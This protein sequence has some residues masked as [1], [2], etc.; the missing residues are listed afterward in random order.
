MGELLGE[1]QQILQKLEN[2][3]CPAYLVGGGVRDALMGR[4]I[5]DYDIATAA[6]PDQVKG[7][8]PEFRIID[9]GLKHGTVT[10][11][12]EIGG[13]EITTFRTESTYSDH[14]RPD[15]VQFTSN[16]IDDLSRRDF[17]M[18]AIALG[19]DGLHDPFNGQ[20]DIEKG[21]IR[22]VGDPTTRFSEDALRILR[23]L[24]FSATLGFQIEP[25]TAAAIHGCAPLLSHVSRERIRDE[26]V[27]LLCGV[28][29]GRI[30]LDYA[31]VITQMI[32]ELAPAV[33]FQQ[34]THYHS[35]DVYTHIVK[36]VE[37]VPPTPVLRLA[38]LL[39]DI[40]KPQTFRLDEAGVGH[41]Y[42]HAAIGAP[43]AEEVLR[44]LRL[45]NG[46]IQQIVPLVQYH[47]LTRDTPIPKLPKLIARLGETGFF[48]LLA[49]DK[50]DSGAKHPPNLCPDDGHD[51]WDEI[52][53]A[54]RSFLATKPPLT[55]SDLAVDGN[56]AMNFGLTGREIGLALS[57]L[58]SQILDDKLENNRESLLF[59]L[60]NYKNRGCCSSDEV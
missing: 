26:L 37:G 16:L 53:A 25:D 42:R 55:V 2:S 23:G 48:N 52:E 45:S 39:H 11:L 50:A 7:V 44:R 24:R 40:A 22:C 46:E 38:A 54:A 21:I 17:T 12:T 59:A 41:F 9:T 28:F 56:D 36:T 4:A 19:L 8:F 30:L 6:T 60:E 43:V 18:N 35:F 47:G 49:L 27:R 1:I 34:H 5:H 32:P 15:G 57:H 58:L 29:A 31:D 51:I 3:G 10:L 20:L 13:V 33:G 14:R